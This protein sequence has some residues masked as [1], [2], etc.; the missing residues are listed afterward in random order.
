MT[1]IKRDFL[2]FLKQFAYG[3]LLCAGFT[4]Q[5]NAMNF[6]LG[7][8]KWAQ[9]F[10][11]EMQRAAR[12]LEREN[13]YRRENVQD[14]IDNFRQ[15]I[16]LLTDKGVPANDARI[17][18]LRDRI[19]EQQK[20]LDRGDKWEDL[21]QD[22]I[23]GAWGHV[24][25][26]MK[27]ARD[28]DLQG[29]RILKQGLMDNKGARERLQDTLTAIKETLKDP[30]TLKYLAGFATATTLG[31]AG[32]YYLTKLGYAYAESYIGQPPSIVKETSRRSFREAAYDVFFGEDKPDR[33][34]SDVVL[35]PDNETKARLF[36]EGFTQEIE[37][38]LPCQLGLF[39]G[40]PGTGKTEFA[41]CFVA[42]TCEKI[43]GV[44]YA[45]INC[46]LL[47]GKDG[48]RQLTELFAWARTCSKP[49]VLFFDEFDSIGRPR[50]TLTS[51]ERDVVNLFLSE[52]GSTIDKQNFKII[53][54]TN[55][56]D[57]LD[58]AILSR[59]DKKIPFFLPPYEEVV[60]IFMKKLEKYIINDARTYERD[61]ETIAVHLAIAPDVDTEY[62]NE[63]SKK[64]V[65]FSGRDIDNATS[66]MRLCAY[67]SSANVL[68][69]DI[70]EY[71]VND[72]VQ[73][74]AKDRMAAEKQRA[75]MLGTKVA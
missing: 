18:N 4:Q 60:K 25:N 29:D 73:E 43:P 14:A 58:T 16:D 7:N 23:G 52:T 31:I 30:T 24:M 41:K 44:H 55:H 3:L 59:I 50:E 20:M 10:A 22:I 45:I 34:L 69:K 28:K 47:K 8:N 13:K 63:I 61:G 54:A 1:I 2:A 51:E 65:G 64:M 62:I 40:P 15:Q 37:L 17:Q 49:L 6:N 5:L 35:S 33:K 26:E 19:T 70:V 38:E 27:H 48:V 9:E 74:I 11:Q 57:D 12:D 56:E 53:L 39:Y 21:G 75:K 46:P 32:S 67:R 36:A 42:Q 71:V 72:K 68:T 66:E